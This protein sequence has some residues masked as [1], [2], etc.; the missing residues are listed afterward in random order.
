MNHKWIGHVSELKNE[1]ERGVLIG[2]GPILEIDDLGLE[3][4]NNSEP[5]NQVNDVHFFPPIPPEGIDLVATQESLEKYYLEEA[6]K[7]AGGN[8]SKA[9][10]FLKLNHHT[11]RYR[12]KKLMIE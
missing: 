3:G 7:L 10:R 2:K 12:R 11:F 1:I 5:P 6:L 4:K 8:E 9:A